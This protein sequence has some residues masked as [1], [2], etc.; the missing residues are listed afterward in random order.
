MNIDQYKAHIE[1]AF[2]K[3]QQGISKCSPELLAMDGM[4]GKKTRHL[5]NNLLDMSGARYLEIGIWLGSSTCS[6]VYKNNVT[7]AYAIDNWSEYGGPK[8]QFQ[9]NLERFGCTDKVK[10]IEHDFMKLDVSTFPKFNIYLFDGGH[11]Y[12]DHVMALWHMMDC[13]EDVFLFIVDDWNWRNVRA[14]TKFAIEQCDLTILHGLEIRM[15]TDDTDTP[16]HIAKEEFWNGVC[17]LLLQKKSP[18]A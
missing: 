17:V 5:Y 11:E 8:Q 1:R 14:A 9:D 6:A 2:E 13:L 12:E 18:L 4:T 16:S 10:F 7:Y 3:A 15:T